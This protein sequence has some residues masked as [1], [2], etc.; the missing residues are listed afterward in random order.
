MHVE[1]ISPLASVKMDPNMLL[2]FICTIYHFLWPVTLPPAEYLFNEEINF[3]WNAFGTSFGG[4][5]KCFFSALSTPNPQLYNLVST[6]RRPMVPR[7]LFHD[8]SQDP[9]RCYRMTGETP[10]SLARIPEDMQPY[11][12]NHGRGRRHSHLARN[13]VLM[14]FIW[15]RQYPTY[16]ML[17]ALFNMLPAMISSRPIFVMI[18]LLWC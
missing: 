18:P 12:D 9:P 10:E 2:L 11:L 7:D 4:L 6:Q 16:D 15:L 3:R 17:S 5:L 13:R 8:L 1:D 14:A